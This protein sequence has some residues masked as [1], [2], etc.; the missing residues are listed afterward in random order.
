MFLKLKVE[1]YFFVIETN[2]NS[3]LLTFA[4]SSMI[5]LSCQP[6]SQIANSF[7]EFRIF[8]HDQSLF[9]FSN[10]LAYQIISHIAIRIKHCCIEQGSSPRLFCISSLFV[11]RRQK[12]N[13]IVTDKFISQ[14]NF[15]GTVV[16]DGYGKL[17]ICD[18]V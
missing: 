12:K 15:Q 11:F 10:H 2:V 14:I 6:E 8:F 7:L 5:N 4:F 9:T 18:L 17:I 16:I 1:I 3:S 13:V